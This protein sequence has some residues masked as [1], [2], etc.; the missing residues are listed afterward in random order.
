MIILGLL[1]PS[2]AAG[3]N[4][5][6]MVILLDRSGS[7]A[8]TDPGG[9]SVP[10]ALFLLDQAELADP[11]NTVSVVLFNTHVKVIPEKGL[12]S[13]FKGL[14]EE[15]MKIGPPEGLTELED[16]F[17]ETRRLLRD[18]KAAQKRVVLITDGNPMPDPDNGGRYPDPKYQKIITQ[19]RERIKSASQAQAF[20]LAKACSEKLSPASI[21]NI[22]GAILPKFGDDNIRIYPIGLT[23][24]V[25]AD[26]LSSIALA[27]T[28]DPGSFKI[29]SKSEELIPAL[30]RV[31]P[32]PET[33]LRLYDSEKEK[34]DIAGLQQW[35]YTIPIDSSASC[36]RLMV[37]YPNPQKA[38]DQVTFAVETPTGETI[39]QQ[40]PSQ[41]DYLAARDGKGNKVFERFFIP[42][43]GAGSYKIYLS[44][45]Q[46][47][48]LLPNVIVTADARTTLRLNITAN[49]SEADAGTDVVIRA[50]V[51]DQNANRLALDRVEAD[52]RHRSGKCYSVTLMPLTGGVLET[53]FHIPPDAPIGE[54][55]IRATGIRGNTGSITGEGHLKVVPPQPVALIADI[56]YGSPRPGEPMT[57]SIKKD[58]LA[59]DILGDKNLNAAIK[60]IE[61]KTDAQPPASLQLE[62]TP[63]ED[64]QGQL[65]DQRRWLKISRRDGSASD[66]QPFKF[67][68][69]AGLPP[70]ITGDLESGVFQGKLIV[71][72]SPPAKEPLEISVI[73][74][75]TIPELLA[76]NKA[77]HGGLRLCIRCSNPGCRQYDLEVESTSVIDQ[78]VDVIVSPY[79]MNRDELP[80]PTEQLLFTLDDPE[81]AHITVPAKGKKVSIG[82]KAE[83]LDPVLQKG[84]YYSEITVDGKQIRDLTLPVK[85]EIPE[86]PLTR[87]L[88]W[89]SL[90]WICLSAAFLIFGLYRFIRN[91]PY[92]EGGTFEW[93][94]E[95]LSG[96]GV[97]YRNYFTIRKANNQVVL[98]TVNNNVTCNNKTVPS[99]GKALGRMDTVNIG[100]EE[101]SL[102]ADNMSVT[103]TIVTSAF[104]RTAH[105]A[106][107]L[108]GALAL[109]AGIAGL[110]NPT[111]LCPLLGG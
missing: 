62:L 96:P 73:L 3:E 97:S 50:A 100:A 54:Y 77:D 70:T 105:M 98:T 57:K 35:S 22:K 58:T 89:I 4:N 33:V 103:A 20:D 6:D 10:S 48:G 19:Y 79:M 1:L 111:L 27:T 88:R 76:T 106:H 66:T 2:Y 45:S 14:R 16:G 92:F 38:S 68:I 39:N 67:A 42:D 82:L 7:M 78:E 75:L 53:G 59:F 5:M 46:T 12:N 63:L 90:G 60:D 55:L 95:E 91:R 47:T 21:E 37:V 80:V 26:L 18:S 93:F 9:L 65:L 81:Q 110:F 8:T 99:R 43:T 94:N 40:S 86:F 69:E 31:V 49:P 24:A 74:N 17:T 108:I 25:N 56:P 101:L 85:V 13:D 72:S 52:L 61:I 102:T 36:L 11:A 34:A 30:N 32:L 44:T 87:V 84:V 51:E 64:A 23:Q 29:V 109:I 15:I 107:L 41:G 71:T 104:S 28:F 83:V